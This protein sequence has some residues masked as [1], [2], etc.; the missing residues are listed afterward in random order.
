[1]QL[2]GRIRTATDS[3][4]QVRTINLLER[5]NKPYHHKLRNAPTTGQV[6]WCATMGLIGLI[7]LIGQPLRYA[8][9]VR[10][11]NNQPIITTTRLLGDSPTTDAPPHP[12]SGGIKHYLTPVGRQPNDRRRQRAAPRCRALPMVG[13]DRK[14]I[15][16]ASGAPSQLPLACRASARRQAHKP[17][18]RRY[19]PKQPLACWATA[20]RQAPQPAGLFRADSGVMIVR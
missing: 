2:Y 14:S 11:R 3:N 19:S 13:L 5:C 20:Q 10:G 9:P 17:R 4:G 12:P 18:K 7:R 6:S 1:M 15:S 8:L 16:R